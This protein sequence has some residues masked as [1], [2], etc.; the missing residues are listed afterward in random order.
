VNRRTYGL[1]AGIAGAL[2]GVWY[3]RRHSSGV[4]YGQRGTVIFDNTPNASAEGVI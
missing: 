3:W 2:V 4:D 1:L